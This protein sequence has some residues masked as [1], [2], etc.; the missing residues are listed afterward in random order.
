[1]EQTCE[2]PHFDITVDEN[3]II[4]GAKEIIKKLRPT[5]PSDK[6]HF[7]VINFMKHKIV[8]GPTDA[9]VFSNCYIA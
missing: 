7:K 6:L 9:F 1:M 8:S 3:E 5:W 2:E 4:N